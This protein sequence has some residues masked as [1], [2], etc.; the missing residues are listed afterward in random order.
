MKEPK[1]QNIVRQLS[2]CLME[3]Y[4]GFQVISIEYA[5]KQ[6]KKFKPINIIYKPTKHIETEPLCYFSEK[7]TLTHIQNQIKSES[8]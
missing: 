6:R 2:S 5:R 1:K 3:K 4:N 7:L 8:S